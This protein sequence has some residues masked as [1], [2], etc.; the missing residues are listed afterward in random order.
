MVRPPA[1][2]GRD[3]G[4]PGLRPRHHANCR[5]AFVFDAEGSNIE[6]VCR[7]GGAPADP[8]GS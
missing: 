3:N 8:Q 7:A 2:G 6:A 5:A 4:P 1:A